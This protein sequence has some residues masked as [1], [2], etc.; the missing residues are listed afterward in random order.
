V[1][2]YPRDNG[3]YLLD[4]K[5][6]NVYNMKLAGISRE[7]ITVS[8]LCTMEEERLFYSHRRM[9]ECRGNLGAFLMLE[10]QD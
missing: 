1:F 8:G 3:K 7:R 6:A 10:E 4:Q 5:A 2:L 9:G